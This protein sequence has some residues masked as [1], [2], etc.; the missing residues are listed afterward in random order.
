[1]KEVHGLFRKAAKSFDAAEILLEHGDA[2]FAVSRIYYGYFYVAEA[3][4]LFKGLSFSRH[5]QVI[6]QYG[7]LFARTEGLAPRYHRAL[8]RTF[9]LR[10]LADYDAE[11]DL[12][13]GEV[14]ELIEEGRAFLDAAKGYLDR[15]DR[16]DQETPTEGG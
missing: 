14:R 3:L 10:Q 12:D 11:P 5:G 7:R 6:S 2:D 9:S 1:M 15:E 16:E 8:I 13:A 4:L